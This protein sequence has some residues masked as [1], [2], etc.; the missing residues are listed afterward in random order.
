MKDAESDLLRRMEMLK[1]EHGEWTYDIPLP[2]G[3]WTR[4]NLGLP[5]TRL[6]RSLQ[7]LKDVL[8]ESWTS[9]RILDLGCLDGIFSIECA[10]Q[11]AA[12]VIGVDVR[13]G[14][15][16]KCLLAQTALGLKNLEFRTGDV[17]QVLTEQNETFDAILCSGLLYHLN[18]PDVFDVI[19]EIHA[20]SGRVALIDTHVSLSPTATVE[21]QGRTYYGQMYREHDEQAT[22][23]EMH[24][25][26][27]SSFG[28]KVSFWFSRPSLIN[29]FAHA[30]FTSIYECF[31]PP[32]LN[33]GQPGLEHRD[34]C[35][36]V[37]L[38]GEAVMLK[39]SPA[40]NTLRE[41][42]PEGSLEYS[43]SPV[44]APSVFQRLRQRM[45]G[46][47]RASH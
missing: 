8:G 5:H 37:C 24:R 29:A 42:W 15:I 32:H 16:E 35:T 40:V 7:V 21:F 36:I 47:G 14:H 22:V 46:R 12:R 10:L 20:R 9:A 18:V 34:R 41:D 25:A 19:Q 31:N 2:G 3:H 33:F 17:R 27:L 44:P 43:P 45:L 23:E 28:N 11:G 6:R 13:H 1:S 39:T 4:G 38:K 26:G 30:G